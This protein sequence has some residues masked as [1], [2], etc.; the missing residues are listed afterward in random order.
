MTT[1]KVFWTTR[2]PFNGVADW[3]TWLDTNAGSQGKDWGWYQ[4]DVVPG[5]QDERTVIA[6][7]F[8]SSE[9]AMLFKLASSCEYYLD[10]DVID[11]NVEQSYNTRI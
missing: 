7:W 10:E 5:E 4:S 1:V 3:Q 9:V 2:D 8:T 11:L 6:I